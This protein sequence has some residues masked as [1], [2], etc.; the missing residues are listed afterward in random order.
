MS[1]FLHALGSVAADR[2]HDD[3]IRVLVDG[4]GADVDASVNGFSALDL[5]ARS[6]FYD[7]TV[8]LLKEFGAKER[9][10]SNLMKYAHYELGQTTF[11]FPSNVVVVSTTSLFYVRV[12]DLHS[13][14]IM[15]FS[16]FNSTLADS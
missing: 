13:S 1:P 2:G 15:P 11:F 9:F 6:G 7:E 16:V 14:C 10:I 4:F 5:A 3:I 8:R 12:Y